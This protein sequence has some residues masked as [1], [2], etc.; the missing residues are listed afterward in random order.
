MVEERFTRLARLVGED[1][2]SRLKSAH[3]TIVGLGAVGSYATEALARSGIGHLRLIDFDV[4]SQSNLNRQLYALH[5]TLGQPKTELAKARVMDI[6]PD[7]S[8]E[9]LRV[10]VNKD[11]IDEALSPTPDMLVDAIDS[12]NP[13]TE[14]ITGCLERDIPFISAMGAALRTDPAF[15]RLGPLS[16][17]THCPLSAIL[18][19][20]LRRRG[21]TCDFP[22][23]YSCE[24]LSG[25]PEDMLAPAEAGIIEGG[26]A[27][28]PM[29]S[30][31]TIPGI[32]GLMMANEVI[33]RITQGK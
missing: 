27:R 11:S 19:K 30:L 3:V 26:R 29:G 28:R 25:L 13:K 12:L 9:T 8:V 2:L 23:V 6:N 16:K 32:F 5:S 7:C 18:R 33:R 24:P 20:R 1:G 15:I 17:A 4:V 22:C 14:L 31:P 21:T 10:L